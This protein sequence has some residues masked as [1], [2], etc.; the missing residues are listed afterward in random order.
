MPLDGSRE[1]YDLVSDGFERYLNGQL[2]RA[3]WRGVMPD[4]PLTRASLAL[5]IPDDLETNPFEFR[6]FGTNEK[7]IRRSCR[8]CRD[9]EGSQAAEPTL[10]RWVDRWI[11]PSYVFMCVGSPSGEGTWGVFATHEGARG[12]PAQDAK[13]EWILQQVQR[14]DLVLERWC[15]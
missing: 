11:Y 4:V 15:A 3:L 2:R 9:G 12:T 14:N 6:A 1:M 10:G 5:R 8:I 13:I 7:S